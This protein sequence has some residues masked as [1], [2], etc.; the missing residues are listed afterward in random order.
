MSIGV[1]SCRLRRILSVLALCF[2]AALQGAWAAQVL[3]TVGEQEITSE[4]LESTIA[5]SPVA[6]QFPSMDE[7]EQARIRGDMLVRL[8]NAEILYQEALSRGLDHSADFAREVNNFRTGLLS[9]RYQYALRDAITIPQAVE[10]ALQERFKGDGDALAAAR[11]LYV[12]PRYQQLKEKRLK[13]LAQ[14]YHLKRY[15]ERLS[16]S[17]GPDT[18]IAQGDGFAVHYQDL[19]GHGSPESPVEE[20][21]Q[22]QELTEL[23][24]MARAAVDEGIDIE[25][26]MAHYQRRLLGQLLL[27]E[28][29]RE[30]IP[31]RQVLTDYFQ[32]HP[33][34]GY[35]PEIREIGQIVVASRKEA[36]ALRKR[37]QAGESLFVLAER[38]SIDPYGKAHAGD[39]GWL[40]EGTGMPQIEAAL[41][42]LKD[43]ELSE[44]IETPKGFHL[45]MI[46]RRQPAQHKPFVAV[47][48]RVRQA[49]LQERLGPYIQELVVRH[50]VQWTMPDHEPVGALETQGAP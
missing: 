31:D 34:L 3:A 40:K 25:Q 16:G 48:D 47:A 26:Q 17:P 14:R 2:A 5:S 42:G 9:Q 43:G 44:V 27:N 12:S 30:W 39:M 13:E 4:Q 28:K 41:A 18:V 46:R 35:V 45:V 23:L 33:E 7:E 20:H 21:E 24:L 22:L 36:E 38:Y 19:A 6:I 10:K 15:P 8:V 1:D 49:Y 32:R 11:S 29:E 50:P 37:I